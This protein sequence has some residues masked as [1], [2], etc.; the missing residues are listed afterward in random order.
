MPE[1]HASNGRLA[2]FEVDLANTKSEL[3]NLNTK[4]DSNQRDTQDSFRNLTDNFSSQMTRLAVD[5]GARIDKQAQKPTNWLQF[6]AA[7]ATVLSL[8]GGVLYFAIGSIDSNAERVERVLAAETL[9]REQDVAAINTLMQPLLAAVKE[10][11]HVKE[12]FVAVDAH[13]K[14]DEKLIESKWSK[15]A[16]DEYEKRIDQVTAIYVDRAK[17]DLAEIKAANATT[18][19]DQIKRPEILT[20]LASLSTQM[21]AGFANDNERYTALSQRANDMQREFGANFTLGDAVKEL[22]ARVNQIIAT[23]SPPPA[24]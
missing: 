14:A 23:P 4:L 12:E 11:E 5:L 19:A 10:A 13:F 22:Q 17:S 20:D 1:V 9:K 6:I 8:V 3:K 7:A 21:A 18:A 24:K 16:Q 15:D 2:A